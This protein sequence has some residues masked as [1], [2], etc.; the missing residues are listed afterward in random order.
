[1]SAGIRRAHRLAEDAFR[2]GKPIKPHLYRV[3]EVWFCEVVLRNGYGK[4]GTVQQA[5]KQG[6]SGD[7]W[8][9]LMWTHAEAAQ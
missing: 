3:D 8:R 5:W 4:G 2:Q 1:M 9:R 7:I 6:F